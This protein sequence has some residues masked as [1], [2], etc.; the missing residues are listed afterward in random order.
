MIFTFHTVDHHRV[1]NES[2]EAMKEI[3][4]VGFLSLLIQF[5]AYSIFLLDRIQFHSIV[6]YIVYYTINY[7]STMKQF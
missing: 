1:E 3:I 6:Q 5:F 4:R 2:T 7:L